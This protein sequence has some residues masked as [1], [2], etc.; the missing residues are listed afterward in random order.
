MASIT[1][2]KEIYGN[3]SLSYLDDLYASTFS[4]AVAG[5][6]SQA[7]RIFADDPLRKMRLVLVAATG[8]MWKYVE[9]IPVGESTQNDSQTEA[10]SFGSDPEIK[11]CEQIG[12]FI[13]AGHLLS[14]KSQAAVETVQDIFRAMK[15]EQ[16]DED[17]LLYGRL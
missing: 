17:E 16:D 10:L 1:K 12:E 5:V 7:E 8:S 2:L 6:V 9:S 11:F 15:K 4:E 3:K 14:D 13:E